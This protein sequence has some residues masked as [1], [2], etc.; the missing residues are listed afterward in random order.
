M[1]KYIGATI[2]P[3]VDTISR[4]RKTRSAWRAS[5]L[6]SY[7]MKKII[8]ELN[9][10]NNVDLILPYSC[11]EKY[12]VF[13]EKSKLGAGLFHD[14]LIIEVNGEFTLEDLA[15][16]KDDVFG[17]FVAK[18]IKEQNEVSKKDFIKYL[19][20]YINFY[21]IEKELQSS[22]NIIFE[23]SKAL[24]IME[25]Q[26]QMCFMQFENN[27]N[28]LFDFFKNKS[29]EN[30]TLENDAYGSDKEIESL[31]EIAWKDIYNRL[32]DK[33][34]I[35]KI[36]KDGKSSFKNSDDK[37]G[38]KFFNQKMKA[39]FRKHHKYYAVVRADG[40]GIGKIIES[41]R[42]KE[43]YQKF[44]NCLFEF[45]KESVDVIKDYDGLPIFAGGDDLLFFAPIIN[46]TNEKNKNV[47]ELTTELSNKFEEKLKKLMQELEITDKKGTLSFGIAMNYY[48]YPL[49]EAFGDSATEL[50]GKAKSYSGK[51]ATAVRLLKGSSKPIEFILN[52]SEKIN[53]QNFLNVFDFN[54]SDKKLI[55]GVVYTLEN[56][57]EILKVIQA[58]KDKITTFF[59][60]NFNKGVHQDITRPNGLSRE[61]NKILCLTID[62][63]QDYKIETVVKLLRFV[64]FLTEEGNADE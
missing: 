23:M 10:N 17:E 42:E 64:M 14:R 12:K 60:N 6:F 51:D 30:Y 8:I 25:L 55:K 43:Q 63:G 59:V 11:E 16:I 9:A 36:I 28:Y 4:A 37:D 52:K 53:F 22:E 46:S 45:A 47:F 41:F 7:L 54:S 33:T 48:K 2:G 29:Y 27:R 44:S 38:Y 57:I 18:A 19:D 56:Q 61:I 13:D 40:D 1:P 49:Y 58:D 5:Y 39:E 32:N 50:F 62:Y 26:P 15:D 3:I 34:E 31:P 24:D 35:D 20:T 21:S